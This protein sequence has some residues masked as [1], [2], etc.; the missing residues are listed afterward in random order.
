MRYLG[1]FIEAA[2]S[3]KCSLDNVKRS[4]Y[5]SFVH[6]SSVHIC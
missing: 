3:F 6:L 2:G 1:V 5:R 4:F